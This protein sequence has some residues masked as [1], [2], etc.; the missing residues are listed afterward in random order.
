MIFD[1]RDP[2]CTYPHATYTRSTPQ[3]GLILTPSPAATT[4]VRWSSI[5]NPTDVT[6]LPPEAR[7]LRITLHAGD[8][9][10]LPAGWWHHVRQRG[11]TI[12]LNWWYDMEMR[13]MSWVWLSFLRGEGDNVCDGNNDSPVAVAVDE[14]TR[15]APD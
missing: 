7:P 15:R 10:Y 14:E 2:E 12:A 11:V 3:S 8:T 4:P 9:L 6:S 13:G 1:L 5:A